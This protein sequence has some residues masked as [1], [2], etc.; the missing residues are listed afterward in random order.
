MLPAMLRSR[1]KQI[2][3]KTAGL[4]RPAY[5]CR[6]RH[7]PK[8]TT[9]DRRTVLAFLLFSL[10]RRVRSR[11]LARHRPEPVQSAPRNRWRRDSPR[12][13][14]H[15]T[16]SSVS[17]AG[18]ISAA[19]TSASTLAQSSHR[20]NASGGTN[21]GMRSCT[22]EERAVR[23]RGDDGGGIE[24][25][26]VRPGPG[27]VQ[28]GE[29][30]RRRGAVG[31]AFGAHEIRPLR[32]AGFSQSLPFIKAVGRNE[33]A[34]PPH[35]VAKGG[36]IEH[37]FAARIDEQRKRLRVLDPGRQQAP[38]HQRERALAVVRGAR[39]ESAGSAP[40]YSAA[41]NSAARHSETAPGSLPASR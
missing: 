40:R 18:A 22:A 2:R 9:P 29:G 35:G 41:G 21:T 32:R 7:A 34:P 10:S 27:L 23:R 28:A 14:P 36:F 4:A 1:P 20:S 19:A 16:S 11:P 17:S 37:G 13:K 26:A 3:C 38:A 30:E 5:R 8:T 33:A 39:R 24:L 31:A 12:S 15:R 6:G 25:F